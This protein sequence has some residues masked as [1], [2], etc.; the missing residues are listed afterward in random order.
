MPPMKPPS[1]AEL[2][3]GWADTWAPVSVARRWGVSISVVRR[4]LG[5]GKLDFCQ[6]AGQLRIPK[7]AVVD[8]EQ[9]EGRPTI[10]QP[11]VT[12]KRHFRAN[13]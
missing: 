9:F 3:A 10:G 4:L 1:P 12:A 2:V 11:K 7:T 8:Y 6:I 5:T 13:A